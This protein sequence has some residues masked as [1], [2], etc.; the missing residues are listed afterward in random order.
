[1]NG[2][3]GPLPD[4]SRAPYFSMHNWFPFNFR[5]LLLNR[6]IGFRKHRMY[7]PLFVIIYK[8]RFRDEFRPTIRHLNTAQWRTYYSTYIV[9]RRW[10]VKFSA[11]YI[12][13][14]VVGRCVTKIYERVSYRH[15]TSHDTIDRACVLTYFCFFLDLSVLIDKTKFSKERKKID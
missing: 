1:M 4:R 3:R 6:R 9:K 13:T 2:N 5:I 12:A 14:M 10:P 11:E 15:Q 7:K 8:H